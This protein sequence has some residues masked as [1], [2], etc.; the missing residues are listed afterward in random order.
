MKDELIEH[1]KAELSDLD[2]DYR[3]GAWEEFQE[4]KHKR[5]KIILWR[6]ALSAAAILVIAFLLLPGKIAKQDDKNDAQVAAVIQ[7]TN[8]QTSQAI[9]PQAIVESQQ[10]I[11]HA[12]APIVTKP[13]FVRHTNPVVKA[14]VINIEDNASVT[15]STADT[16]Q[17]IATVPVTANTGNITPSVVKTPARKKMSMEE[18]LEKEAQLTR[19]QQ[20]VTTG[21]KK[22]SFGLMVGQA[23]DTRSKTNLNLGTQV[24]YAINNKLAISTGINYNELG[25]AKKI[26]PAAGIMDKNARMLDGAEASMAGIDIPLEL[27]YKVNKKIYARVGVSAYSILSQQQSLKYSQQ[28]SVVNTYFDGAGQQRIE[29]VS[30]TEVSTEAVPDEKL[31][32]NKYVGLYNLSVG[33]QQKINNRNTLSFEPYVKVPVSGYSE[34]K[35]N[36][37]QGGLRIKVDF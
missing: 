27:Q 9:V 28:L 23:L 24:S 36:L 17:Y 26:S 22:W 18:Y 37:V 8:P 32:Q 11:K 35:L 16:Q 30:R 6:R 21:E 1:I 7:K 3:P 34:Q 14:Q 15:P 10:T 20:P 4:R 12:E 5:N 2:F 33:F 13:Q 25:G 29:T 31:K 19:K